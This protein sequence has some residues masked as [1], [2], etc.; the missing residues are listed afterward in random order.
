MTNFTLSCWTRITNDKYSFPG[1]R[2]NNLS[3]FV[4][5]G[6]FELQDPHSTI[7]VQ[8]LIAIVTAALR[9]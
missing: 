7:G 6:A 9:E 3:R 1:E 8:I 4:L 2:G 5:V